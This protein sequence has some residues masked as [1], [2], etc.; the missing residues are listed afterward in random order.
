VFVRALTILTGLVLSLSAIAGKEGG[1]G[2][3]GAFVCTNYLGKGIH[4]VLLADLWEAGI[5]PNHPVVYKMQ[6]DKNQQISDAFD[7]LE[8]I[9]PDFGKSTRELWKSMKF[10]DEDIRIKEVVD[11]HSNLLPPEEWGCGTPQGMMYYDGQQEAVIENTRIYD[12]Q[13]TPTDFA[14]SETHEAI[15]KNLRDHYG[16]TDSDLARKI[17]G[18]LY[19][20]DPIVCLGLIH[21][22]EAIELP[23]DKETWSCTDFD[24][25]SFYLVH[26]YKDDPWKSSEASWHD[27]PYNWRVRVDKIR[28]KDATFETNERIDGY[29]EIDYSGYRGLKVE[30]KY[31]YANGTNA[32]EKIEKGPISTSIYLSLYPS[33]LMSSSSKCEMIQTPP[34]PPLPANGPKLKLG[35]YA[36]GSNPN[37]KV[38][39]DLKYLGFNAQTGLMS[40]QWTKSP[41][42]NVKQNP[43]LIIGKTVSFRQINPVFWAGV[44]RDGQF[45][46]YR[47]TLTFDNEFA[48]FLMNAPGEDKDHYYEGIRYKKYVPFNLDK[49]MKENP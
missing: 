15:Y 12:Q 39:C 9:F 8:S 18:C 6:P 36:V 25:N 29:E 4:K 35:S 46:E 43:C 19:T 37:G 47:I 16:F 31:V 14:A 40:I 33:R 2:A 28:G 20:A 26:D 44:A 11:N 32:F 7:T 34:P 41:N 30:P 10:Y 21:R 45:S 42:P 38:F 23:K 13:S 17:N 5:T 22:N 24:K 49:W 3:G 48:N 27:Y 1:G